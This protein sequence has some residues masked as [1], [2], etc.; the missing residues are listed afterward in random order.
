[1][2][3]SRRLQATSEHEV[4]LLRV[5]YEFDGSLPVWRSSLL[6]PHDPQRRYFATP[7][8]LMH[9]LGQHVL[10]QSASIAEAAG[11]EP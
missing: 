3:E 1:M 11:I 2:N 4:F 9:F 10:T 7:G 8:A 5:W 6:L